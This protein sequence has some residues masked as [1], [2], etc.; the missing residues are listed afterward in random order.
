M[1]SRTL[2][3][4]LR[5]TLI[6]GRGHTPG[7]G[8]T[9]ATGTVGAGAN[10]AF[11]RATDDDWEDRSILG[12]LGRSLVAGTLGFSGATI[13]SD[14]F[15]LVG[16]AGGTGLGMGTNLAGDKVMELAKNTENPWISGGTSALTNAVLLSL[17]GTAV[18]TSMLR[19]GGLRRLAAMGLRKPLR[20]QLQGKPDY[21]GLLKYLDIEASGKPLES[22]LDSFPEAKRIAVSAKESGRSPIAALAD[23]YRGI[24]VNATNSQL[25]DAIT[26]Y[27][28]T[29]A[30]S[31]M[32]N[33]L[34]GNPGTTLASILGGVPYARKANKVTDLES[35]LGSAKR[36][37]TSGPNPT[38]NPTGNPFENLTEESLNNM[39]VQARNHGAPEDWIQEFEREARKHLRSNNDIFAIRPEEREAINRWSAA[40]RAEGMSE[41]EISDLVDFAIRQDR[42]ISN[43]DLM[44]LL[45]DAAKESILRRGRGFIDYYLGSPAT[46]RLVDQHETIQNI[47][48]GKHLMAQLY[49]DM[50]MGTASGAVLGLPFVPFTV[51]K[52][53]AEMRERQQQQPREEAQQPSVAAR[54]RQLLG[55]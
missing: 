44:G 28:M 27:M 21:E 6:G 29:N 47:P 7:M 54:V 18:T 48:A 52:H 32:L 51:A 30:G 19:G 17:G 23:F 50:L 38:G 37:G 53:R 35:A 15:G 42:R 14:R 1:P 31:G 22:M 8:Q 12:R 5:T 4:K 26:K 33:Q 3:K 11:A 40:R 25:S 2:A 41:K 34:V 46:K 20:K 10:I 43:V 24:P 36:K 13:G 45:E 55:M 49:E 16:A 9:L 39:L